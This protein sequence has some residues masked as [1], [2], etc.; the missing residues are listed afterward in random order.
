MLNSNMHIVFYYSFYLEG[1][2]WSGSRSVQ[3]EE[4]TIQSQKC[5]EHIVYI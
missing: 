2:K 3:N 4:L 1:D 5:M